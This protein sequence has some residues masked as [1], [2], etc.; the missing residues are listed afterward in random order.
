MTAH[1]DLTTHDLS[2]SPGTPGYNYQIVFPFLGQ[3]T[4]FSPV[5]VSEPDRCNFWAQTVLFFQD[6]FIF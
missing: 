4:K 5:E 2:E 1:V 6:V 3:V